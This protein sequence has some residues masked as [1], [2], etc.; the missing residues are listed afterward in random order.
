MSVERARQLRKN[1]PAPE[2][3]LWNALRELRR[4]GHHFRRQVSIGQ[5]YADFCCHK[6][7]LI[8]EVDGDSHFY[9]SAV[10]YDAIRDA[11]LRREGYRVLRV[12]NGDVMDNLDGVL[13]LV[14]SLLDQPPPLIPPHKGEGDDEH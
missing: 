12:T 9:D 11:V 14:L 5:Y 1:M 7:C 4:V 3:K 8:I 2:A 10:P 13:T 6:K